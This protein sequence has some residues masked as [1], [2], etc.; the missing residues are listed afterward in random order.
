MICDFCLSRFPTNLMELSHDIP[1]YLGGDD[2]QGRRELC[3]RCHDIYENIILFRCIREVLQES[4]LPGVLNRA[5]RV[6]YMSK[7][8]NLDDSKKKDCLKIAYEIKKRF[9]E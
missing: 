4:I 1:K 2:K 6:Y 3:S 8:M 5:N 7:I 9:F